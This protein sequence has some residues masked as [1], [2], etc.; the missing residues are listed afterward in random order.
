MGQNDNN[1]I[2][3]KLRQ[4]RVTSNR[5]FA[6]NTTIVQIDYTFNLVWFDFHDALFPSM[7]F[8]REWVNEFLYLA[9]VQQYRQKIITWLQWGGK[10]E[11]IALH[12]LCWL[13]LFFTHTHTHSYYPAQFSCVSNNTHY[14]V[15]IRLK[16]VLHLH[17][18]SIFIHNRISI[19]LTHI[20]A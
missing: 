9:I 14:S 7:L 4:R 18:Y 17:G 5:T 1:K 12:L 10:R 16:S 13:Y 15:R 19:A 2:L 3:H 11:I 8:H 20:C 6:V